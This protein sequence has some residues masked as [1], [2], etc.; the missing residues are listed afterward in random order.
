MK[1]CTCLLVNVLRPLFILI[2]DLSVRNYNVW[3]FSI[4]IQIL[5]H[6][7]GVLRREVVVSQGFYLRRKALHKEKK[8]C[9]QWDSN[10]VITVPPDL[11]SS[12]IFV[13]K[14]FEIKLIAIIRK[15]TARVRS[16]AIELE[17][18]DAIYK[19]YFP[20]ADFLRCRYR[21]GNIL[22]RHWKLILEQ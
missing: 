15:W 11:Q 2:F 6:I 10:L 19:A 9:L 22:I 14:D 18:L 20:I 4:H 16:T 7:T 5:G 12:F 13:F 8:T 1:Y 17:V 21:L 3:S